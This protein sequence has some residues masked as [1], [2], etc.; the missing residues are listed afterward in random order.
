MET[1]FECSKYRRAAE[2]FKAN[3]C[4]VSLRRV[5]V[6]K[7]WTVTFNREFAV[8]LAKTTS[9]SINVHCYIALSDEL[10]RAD[11]RQHGVH[12]ITARSIPGSLAENSTAGATKP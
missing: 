7:G 8:N 10:S 9:Y 12:L 2:R 11:D 6:F 1:N 4:Y 3:R 5:E